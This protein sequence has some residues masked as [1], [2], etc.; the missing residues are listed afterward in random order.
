MGEWTRE[1]LTELIHRILRNDLLSAGD[2]FTPKSN[3]VAAGLDSLA[4][5]QLMLSIE[6]L[7]TSES[8]A[9]CIHA[10]VSHR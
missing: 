6:N 1:R 9:G 5:T 4:V 8:L 10:Y 3:L 2:E 7:E